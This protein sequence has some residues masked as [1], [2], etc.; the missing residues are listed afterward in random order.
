[1]Q[2]QFLPMPDISQDL[3]EFGL[4]AAASPG[5]ADSLMEALLAAGEP[6]AAT[7]TPIDDLSVAA[8]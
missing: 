4:M 7:A 8:F 6:A 1:M 2:N 3:F 5:F